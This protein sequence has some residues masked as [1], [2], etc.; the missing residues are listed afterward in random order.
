MVLLNVHI[1]YNMA[2]SENVV[3]G[4]GE[5]D[6]SPMELG[7]CYSFQV[8]KPSIGIIQL[9]NEKTALSDMYAAA[10]ASP[11]RCNGK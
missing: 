3:N 11:L 4:H 2:V 9:Q 1:I 5:N 8:P 6:G 10:Y 7:V